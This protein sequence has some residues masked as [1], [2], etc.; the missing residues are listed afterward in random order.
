MI[1]P[2]MQQIIA[3]QA[4]ELR[5][6]SE[7]KQALVVKLSKSKQKRREMRAENEALLREMRSENASLWESLARLD[8]SRHSWESEK[9]TFEEDLATLRSKYEALEEQYSK[10]TAKV[11]DYDAL[12]QRTSVAESQLSEKDS[13]IAELET[14]IR[15]LSDKVSPKA[16]ELPT[17]LFA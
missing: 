12:E 2:E 16:S 6:T 15:V 9:V 7:E 3:T 4:E 11:S 1:F 8:A 17:S 5:S 14:E 13:Y 10:A